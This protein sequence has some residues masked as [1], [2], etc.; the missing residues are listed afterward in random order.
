MIPDKSHNSTV[1]TVFAL[2]TDT[3]QEAA[4]SSDPAASATTTTTTTTTGQEEKLHGL[5]ADA[6]AAEAAAAVRQQ[7]QQQQDDPSMYNDKKDSLAQALL[8]GGCEEIA[9]AREDQDAEK[10]ARAKPEARLPRQD[11]EKMNTKCPD[12]RDAIALM[13]KSSRVSTHNLVM[14]YIFSELNSIMFI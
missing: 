7:Q 6:D 12:N 4:G 5:R 10:N 13:Q 9:T 11:S 14:D 2:Q 8:S 3:Q 1:S